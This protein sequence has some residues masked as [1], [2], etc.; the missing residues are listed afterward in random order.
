[1]PSGNGLNSQFGSCMN[2]F[3]PMVIQ[4]GFRSFV[5]VQNTFSSWEQ[6]SYETSIGYELSKTVLKTT[7]GK[8]NECAN[9]AACRPTFPVG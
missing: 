3:N 6:Y 8:F 1:M 4:N 9:H 7:A 2:S 5:A